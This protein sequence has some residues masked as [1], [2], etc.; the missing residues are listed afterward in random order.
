MEKQINATIIADSINESGNRITSF[1]VNFPRIV[2]AELNTHRALSRNS[3]SSRA[4]PF[5]TMLKNVEENPFIPIAW[6]EDHKGMQGTS[7][8]R[9]TNALVQDWLEGRDNAIRIAEGFSEI[10]GV[11]KQL[12]N[13]LLEPFMYHKAIITATDLENFFHLRCPE[14]DI[15]DG[16][17]YRSKKDA[18]EAVGNVL[19]QN[20]ISN[21]SDI[22]WLKIN[23]GQGEIHIMALAEVMWDAYQESK[24]REMGRGDWHIPFGDNIDEEKLENTLDK[25][26]GWPKAKDILDNVN[27]LDIAKLQIATARCARV[28]YWNYE[29]KDDYEADL[30]LW[31]RL[32]SGDKLHASPFE[33]CAQARGDESRSG[34]FVGWTQ[35]RKTM[36]GECKY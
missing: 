3:A 28:S 24:P 31:E 34:N 13:R 25:I 19:I 21:Q 5:K 23:K 12:C 20:D 4:I 10:H 17:L 16:N 27:F 32:Q 2:L 22:E 18:I 6:Q 11:T 29:G 8:I 36:S 7:Y 35:L 26:S 33:H 15:G 30:K 14:Y 9:H 1:V